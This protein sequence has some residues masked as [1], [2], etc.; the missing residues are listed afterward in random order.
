MKGKKKKSTDFRYDTGPAKI[1]WSA[2]GEPTR[3]ED[4]QALIRFLLPQG[5]DAKSY[6]ARFKEVEKALAGLYEKGKTCGK[7]TLGNQVA[8][9]EEE[10]AKFLRCKYV[11]FLTNATAGFEIAEK[12]AGLKPGDEIIA[13]A[14]TFIASISYPLSIGAKVVISDIDP[15]TMNMDPKDVARK[16]TKKTKMILPVH[17]G[18]YPVDMDPIMALAKKHNITVLED[19]AH[20]FGAKYKG[21][22]AGTIGHFGAFS[23]H[24]V[25][26]ITSLGEG[27]ILCS[28]QA[29]GKD[30]AK[31]RFVGIDPAAKP[32]AHW[33]YDVKALK[34]K[35]EYFAPGNHSSTEAQ[36]LMLRNQMKRLKGII[37]KRKK[38]AEYLNQRFK[39]IPGIVTPPLD[40]KDI[41]SSHH[42]YLFQVD[43]SQ[44]K[45]D[46][47]RV[48][49]EMA[50]KGITQIP[51]FA[52][53]YRFSI[54]KQLGYDT[55]AIAA[56]CPHAE[57]AF[58]HTFTHLPLYEFSM[59][60]IQYMADTIIEIINNMRKK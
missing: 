19:A 27:G 41:T 59:D 4:V 43:P 10:V 35:D 60:D 24:E 16:I 58:L 39:N 11:S 3:L 22:M 30:F 12:F 1:A 49:E 45:G 32:I 54:M 26:N 2:V 40:S 14:I 28:D 34:W 7:L 46:I 44:L 48:K 18:G 33:L 17:I 9:L 56:T 29:C 38:A 13:P 23:F 20:A 57:H 5:K 42:L 25:K 55:K 31:A 50:K 53:L 52:P 15:K 6:E 21:K 51:H 47:Q 37:A 36:A 8:A